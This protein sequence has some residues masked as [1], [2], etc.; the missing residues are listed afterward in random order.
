MGRVVSVHAGAG[1]TLSK[2]ARDAIE[3]ELDGIVGDR[4]R[5]FFRENW[6]D[7]KQAEGVIRRMSD[8]GQRCRLKSL[9]AF[10]RQ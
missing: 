8:I 2:E 1:D 5:G 6:K 3:V 4:H 9:P 10:S 7:D